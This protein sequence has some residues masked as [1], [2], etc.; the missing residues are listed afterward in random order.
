MNAVDGIADAM[1]HQMLLDDDLSAAS[2]AISTGPAADSGPSYD[3]LSLAGIDFTSQATSHTSRAMRRRRQRGRARQRQRHLHD[4]QNPLALG[5]G[6]GDGG[7]EDGDW[8]N[9]YTRSKSVHPHPHPHAHAHHHHAP[10]NGNQAPKKAA[11]AVSTPPPPRGDKRINAS[12]THHDLSLGP[13][14]RAAPLASRHFTGPLPPPTKAAC[15]IAPDPGLHPARPSLRIHLTHTY[16]DIDL[17]LATSWPEVDV[18]LPWLLADSL[19]S[20]GFP[21]QD[22]PASARNQPIYLLG[23]DTETYPSRPLLATTSVHKHIQPPTFLHDPNYPSTIQ[24]ASRSRILIIPIHWLARQHGPASI[25]PALRALFANPQVKFTGVALQS[26]LEPLYK[27]LGIPKITPS[28]R[29]VDLELVVRDWRVPAGLDELGFQFT[30]LLSTSTHAR[31]DAV[32]GGIHIDTHPH[33]RNAYLHDE[34]ALLCLGHPAQPGYP[35]VHVAGWKST[36]LSMATNWDVNPARWTVAMATYAGLDALVSRAVGFAIG[37]VVDPRT[38]TLASDSETPVVLA[39]NPTYRP[40]HV[41]LST[42]IAL[43]Q[44][45]QHGVADSLANAGQDGVSPL[46]WIRHM[47]AF[48]HVRHARPM[49]VGNAH[50]WILGMSSVQHHVKSLRLMR[51]IR[52]KQ[53]LMDRAVEWMVST[54]LIEWIELPSITRGGAMEKFITHVHVDRDVVPL[55][56]DQVAKPTTAALVAFL[57]EELP[58]IPG[59]ARSLLTRAAAIECL[60]WT[61][62]E[63]ALLAE[64]LARQVAADWVREL[65]GQRDWD[66]LASDW[67]GKVKALERALVNRLGVEADLGVERRAKDRERERRKKA[68]KKG[69]APAVVKVLSLADIM[70]GEDSD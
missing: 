63:L 22:D 58:R 15:L 25:S 39:V 53:A 60:A 50:G 35:Q 6:D 4:A 12:G 7:G 23:M 68:G 70:G 57:V 16:P 48:L 37:P 31:I 59:S 52:N 64:P 42:A 9:D 66:Q 36:P 47:L 62:P 44:P 20:G 41:R 46:V 8:D 49:R 61:H 2:A 56:R 38:W 21:T 14:R 11:R 40:F 1:T 19:E 34:D 55:P 32:H 13:R 27:A 67:A 33:D 18:H 45:S 43:A 28:G 51:G 29:V 10:E 26:D 30:P 24:L 3:A 17:V 65:L 54:G 5:D 69:K